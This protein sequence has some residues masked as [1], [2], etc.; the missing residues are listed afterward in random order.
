MSSPQWTGV[1]DFANMLCDKINSESPVRDTEW[2]T[3]K[4]TLLNDGMVK[5]VR[6]FMQELLNTSQDV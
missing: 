2:E 4:M 1:E 6:R 3:L 5:G